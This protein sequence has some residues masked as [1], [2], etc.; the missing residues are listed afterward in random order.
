MIT[1]SLE[2]LSQADEALRE[3]VKKQI[4]ASEKLI[5]TIERSNGQIYRALVKKKKDDTDRPN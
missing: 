3:A 2:R 4:A 1:T 5:L